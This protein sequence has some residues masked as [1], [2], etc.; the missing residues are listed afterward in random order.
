MDPDHVATDLLAALE[1]EGVRRVVIDSIAELERAVGESSG[2]A[3][4]SNYL[5]ALLAALRTREVTLLALTE[6]QAG[7]SEG[8]EAPLYQAAPAEEEWG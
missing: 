8:V 4:V 7:A 1:R 2:S 6:Q 3:R 5:A